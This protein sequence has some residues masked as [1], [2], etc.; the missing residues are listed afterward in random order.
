MAVV[1]VLL[2]TLPA[3]VAM[4]QQPAAPTAKTTNLFI[5]SRE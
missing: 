3:D 1:G 5:L 2:V 4:T